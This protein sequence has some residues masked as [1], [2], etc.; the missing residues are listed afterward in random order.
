MQ[1]FHRC[2]MRTSIITIVCEADCHVTSWI[3]I[4]VAL[5]SIA[6]TFV[7]LGNRII[8]FQFLIYTQ[9]PEIDCCI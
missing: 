4:D 1:I 3:T 8:L 7:V 6:L 9:H 5:V 2:F